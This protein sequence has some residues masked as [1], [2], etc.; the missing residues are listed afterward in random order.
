MSGEEGLFVRTFGPVYSTVTIWPVV[1]AM[2]A[3]VSVMV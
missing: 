1:S 3:S 2:S